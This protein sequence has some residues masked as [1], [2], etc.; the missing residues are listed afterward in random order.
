MRSRAEEADERHQRGYNC[1]Q[2]VACAY[3][4]LVGVSER[5]AFR[6]TEG[7]GLG[8]GGMEGTCGAL[9]GACYLVGLATSDGNVESPGT[10][11]DSY[12]LSRE[13]VRRFGEQNGSVSCRELKGVGSDHGPLRPCP[14]CIADACAFVEDVLFS[15]QFD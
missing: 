6:S 11:R 2:A 8:M 10:K 15:G 5:E 3:A 12:A 4:D 13:I 1:A 14:G 9:T 7:F